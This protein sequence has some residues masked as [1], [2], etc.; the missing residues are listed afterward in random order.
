MYKTW[1]AATNLRPPYTIHPGQKLARRPSGNAPAYGVPTV[2]A[3][4]VAAPAAAPSTASST[5]S[6]PKATPQQSKNSK[7][8]RQL[9]LPPKAKKIHQRRLNNPNQS[10]YVD[11]KGKQNVTPSTKP[12]SDKES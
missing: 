10:E 4:A 11:L 1:L 2:V 5:A 6:K 8:L 9:K 12:T 7:N 3:A